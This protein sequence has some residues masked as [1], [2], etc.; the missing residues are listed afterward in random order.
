MENARTADGVH[1]ARGTE[2]N[3]YSQEELRLM[4]TQ[5]V[6]YLSLKAQ[7]EAKVGAG[8]WWHACFSLHVEDQPMLCCIWLLPAFFPAASCS[9]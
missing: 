3:K 8:R 1:I 4:K 9:S 7:A 6:G 5:D 2:A